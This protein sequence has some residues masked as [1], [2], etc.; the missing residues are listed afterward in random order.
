MYLTEQ[1]Y[2]VPQFI[3]IPKNSF[4]GLQNSIVPLRHMGKNFFINF[5]NYDLANGKE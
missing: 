4:F 1:E 3:F 5:E 2:E